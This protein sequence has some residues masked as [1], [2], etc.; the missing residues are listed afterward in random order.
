MLSLYRPVF[1]SFHFVAGAFLIANSTLSEGRRCVLDSTLSNR[2]P[3]PMP[4]AQ[5]FTYRRSVPPRAVTL[6]AIMGSAAQAY[7]QRQFRFQGSI[8]S[9]NPSFITP[10][11]ARLGSLADWAFR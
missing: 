6:A 1:P 2:I 10:C 7:N 11:Y 5:R 9:I 4:R 8:S 3:P